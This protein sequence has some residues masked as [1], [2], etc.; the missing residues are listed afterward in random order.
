[1]SEVEQRD[2]NGPTGV[3]A[4][5]PK[6]LNARARAFIE[7]SPLALV[8]TVDAAGN[9]DVGL[10][11][12]LPGFAVIVGDATLAM[13]DALAD[14]RRTVLAD[15]QQNARITLLFLLPGINEGLRIGGQARISID[16][17]L[18]ERLTGSGPPVASA[19]V[20]EI[21]EV[22]PYGGEALTRARLWDEASKVDRSRLP[23]VDPEADKTI[24]ADYLS[25][26]Y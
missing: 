15:A 23:G 5:T 3:G 12:D 4:Q 21:E 17:A 16:A 7:L 20:V 6:R 19:L 25:G 24:E 14:G 2:L 18:L 8:T 10:Y 26:L 11:G 9:H 22:F 1:M 13:P